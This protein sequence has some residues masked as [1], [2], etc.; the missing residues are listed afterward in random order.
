MFLLRF[1]G[2]CERPV[3]VEMMAADY[4]SQF[5]DT[6]CGRLAI[7]GEKTKSG[8][9]NFEIFA[10]ICVQ[11]CCILTQ[12]RRGDTADS[13]DRLELLAFLLISALPLHAH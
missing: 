5:P 4:W 1:E 12:Q 2:K 3:Q 10:V 13:G 8:M 6:A 7:S 11:N 9:K